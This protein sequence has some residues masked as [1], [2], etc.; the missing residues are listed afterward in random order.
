MLLWRGTWDMSRARQGSH[1]G[2]GAMGF[3][4]LQ[5]LRV[6]PGRLIQGADE[7]LLCLSG[8]VGDA[9]GRVQASAP[10]APPDYP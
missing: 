10:P 6:Q 3:N 5:G 9:W 2:T 7:L 8:G 4:V 1:L